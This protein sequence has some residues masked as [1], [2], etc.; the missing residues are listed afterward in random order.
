MRR[1]VLRVSASLC[2][3]NTLGVA[4]TANENDIK[5]AYR[6]LALKLHPDVCK[7]DDAEHQFLMLQEAYEILIGKSRGK[8]GVKGTDG[9]DWEFHDWY[10]QFRMSRNKRKTQGGSPASGADAHFD[11]PRHK[12]ELKSQLA[13]LRHRAAVRAQKQRVSGVG[14]DSK[15]TPFAGGNNDGA[16]DLPHQQAHFST[17]PIFN[18]EKADS[19]EQVSMPLEDAYESPSDSGTPD[20]HEIP[21]QESSYRKRTFTPTSEV[22]NHVVSQLAGLKRKGALRQSVCQNA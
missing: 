18:S 11:P 10:W 4:P 8:E 15:T 22:R 19:Q 13:G 14:S 20:M 12:V 21:E 6:K 1:Q 16:S 3:Y 9:K 5:R 2:P 7:T 17:S